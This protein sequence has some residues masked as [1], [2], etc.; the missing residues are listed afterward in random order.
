MSDNLVGI[1]PNTILPHGPTKLLVDHYH[2]HHPDKG[3]VA[4]YTPTENDVK[5]HFE[6]FRGVDQIEAFAQ[7]TA[8]SCSSFL[9]QLKNKNSESSFI[10]TFISVGS[11]N[12]YSYLKMGETFIS[13]GQIKFYRFRQMVVDGRIYKA[14]KGLNLDEYFKDFTDDKLNNYDISEDFIL[15]AE[16]LDITGRAI[17]NK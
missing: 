7:A 1:A 11:V 15:V 4:S 8:G 5:D 17:K 9:H 10:S 2:W 14:P 12:F 13:I 6:V 16:L 3:I